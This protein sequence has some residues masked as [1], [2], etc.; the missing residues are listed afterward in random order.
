MAESAPLQKFV[1]EA[2]W[3]DEWQALADDKDK[4]RELEKGPHR[5]GDQ[6]EATGGRACGSAPDPTDANRLL[7]T[8]VNT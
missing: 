5:Y 1:A 4:W 3:Q 7:A 8:F 2:G 6:S